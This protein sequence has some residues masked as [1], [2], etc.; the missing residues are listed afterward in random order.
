[1][2]GDVRRTTTL[3]FPAAMGDSSSA[4]NN[5]LRGAES[6]V[7]DVAHPS[8]VTIDDQRP[9][10]SWSARQGASYRV[11]IFDGS[12]VVAESPVLHTNRWTPSSPLPRGRSYVWQVEV[13]SADGRA[14]IIVAP[15][16]RAAHFRMTSIERHRDLVDAK[17][18]RPDDHLLRAILYARADMRAEAVEELNRIDAA[19]P[20]GLQLR[21]KYVTSSTSRVPAVGG[22]KP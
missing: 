7:V 13:K 16:A 22:G 11:S 8:N 18:E 12:K 19:D 3:P 20:V 9:E 15:P 4:A 5:A 14:E 2:L 21:R 10:F 6:S 1:M 17:H